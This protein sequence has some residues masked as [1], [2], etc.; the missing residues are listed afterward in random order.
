MSRS[1][2]ELLVSIAETVREIAL[3]LSEDINVEPNRRRELAVVVAG[4]EQSIAKADAE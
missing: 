3:A 2:R 1:E 4:F